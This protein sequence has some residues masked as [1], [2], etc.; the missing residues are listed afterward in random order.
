MKAIIILIAAMACSSLTIAKPIDASAPGFY[1]AG[2]VGY[3]KAKKA[4]KGGDVANSL[5]AGFGIAGC[6]C[7]IKTSDQDHDTAWDITV[8][9]QITRYFGIEAFYSDLG[10]IMA[11]ATGTGSFYIPPIP[12]AAT[13][14]YGSISGSVKI[15]SKTAGL[16]LTAGYPVLN[17]LRL[18]AKAGGFAFKTETKAKASISGTAQ[19]PGFPVLVPVSQSQSSSDSKNGGSWL[20]GLGAGYALTTHWQLAL[21]WDR[22]FSVDSAEGN[23]DVDVFKGAVQYHF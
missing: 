7:T 3:S 9:Y 23:T 4:P 5:A 21:E 10:Q 2:G 16:A 8:G 17:T 20:F 6:S 11:K 13:N 22:F 1:L 15:Q 12:F 19:A 18:Y 14:L